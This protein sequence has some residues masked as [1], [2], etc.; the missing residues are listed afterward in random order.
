MART[1][2][3]LRKEESDRIAK[4]K[5]NRSRVCAALHAE[6]RAAQHRTY[7]RANS[8]VGAHG[9]SEGSNRGAKQSVPPS[10][11][12]NTIKC[13][14]KFSD[15][16]DDYPPGIYLALVSHQESGKLVATCYADGYELC[17][18]GL[19][20]KDIFPPDPSVTGRRRFEEETTV[21]DALLPRPKAAAAVKVNMVP[22][23]EHHVYR[24]LGPV[25][26]MGRRGYVLSS[27]TVGSE[28]VSKSR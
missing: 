2:I 8:T 9:G 23:H 17:L 28:E 20:D 1:I 12:P 16:N 13:G 11:A 7:E 3:P 22:Q 21:F 24:R 18:K 27:C 19:N 14:I 5:Q 10:P 4:L 26:L 25:S 6:L 15:D